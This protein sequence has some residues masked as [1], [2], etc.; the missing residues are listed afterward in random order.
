MTASRCRRKSTFGLVQ[1]DAKDGFPA[2]ARPAQRKGGH[3][4]TASVGVKEIIGTGEAPCE[5]GIRWR[6]EAAWSRRSSSIIARRTRIAC[7]GGRPAKAIAP[8]VSTACAGAP[9]RSGSS[10]SQESLRES[11]NFEE[12][13]LWEAETNACATCPRTPWTRRGPRRPRAAAHTP[14]YSASNFS[15]EDV[16][17]I[18][19]ETCNVVAVVSAT[20]C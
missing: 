4:R 8:R 2:L 1:D 14:P 18:A 9:C 6:R 7:E 5:M 13:L 20:R 16:P 3:T 19:L 12:A 10:S 17:R 15:D 11:T